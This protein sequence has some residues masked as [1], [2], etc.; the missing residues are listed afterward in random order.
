ME[1]LHN[2]DK[3]YGED[4]YQEKCDF[5]NSV[6]RLFNQDVIKICTKDTTKHFAKAVGLKIYLS[7]KLTP[8]KCSFDFKDNK[9]YYEG[10]F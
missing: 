2:K 9:F 8:R 10:I 6:E 7:D 4:L 3:C 1:V 5:C